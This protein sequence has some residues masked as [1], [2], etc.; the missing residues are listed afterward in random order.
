M[1]RSHFKRLALAAAFHSQERSKSRLLHRRSMLF[2]VPTFSWKAGH[3]PESTKVE[4]PTRGCHGFPLED[5]HAAIAW[6]EKRFEARVEWLRRG[7][8]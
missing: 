3:Q 4:T 8:R 7:A 1:P 5:K 6:T 2:V